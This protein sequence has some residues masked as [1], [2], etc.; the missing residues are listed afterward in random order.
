MII[1]FW[2][3]DL[4][5]LGQKPLHLRINE[6]D[7]IIFL[8][9]PPQNYTPT[10]CHIHPLH[11]IT[12]PRITN[13]DFLLIRFFIIGHTNDFPSVIFSATKN[14]TTPVTI[15]IFNSMLCHHNHPF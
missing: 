1:P 2:N 13:N 9:P 3:G 6:N 5:G 7:F 11:I 12:I 14:N 10:L 8:V 15:K 4:L